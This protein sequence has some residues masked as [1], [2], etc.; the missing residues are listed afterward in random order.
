MLLR[1][2]L[3]RRHAVY[4][5]AGAGPALEHQQDDRPHEHSTGPAQHGNAQHRAANMWCGSPNSTDVKMHA[6]RYQRQPEEHS[7]LLLH[8]HPD[9]AIPHPSTAIP[10]VIRPP[11]L[12]S[13]TEASCDRRR[14]R[15]GV[16]T[17]ELRRPVRRHRGVTDP[18]GQRHHVGQIWRLRARSGGLPRKS[19]NDCPRC[20][21]R[22]WPGRR[23]KIDS[24]HLPQSAL[25]L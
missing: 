5:F 7:G 15:P 17:T 2:G 19:F 8:A 6:H 10:A 20:R 4:G 23:Y 3:F 12:C 22:T 11:S 1:A 14:Q 24:T 9:H 18:H 16:P 13:G 25:P 21:L